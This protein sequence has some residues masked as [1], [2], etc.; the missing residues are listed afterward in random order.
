[1][2]MPMIPHTVVST[3]SQILGDTFLM[4]RFEG[5]SEAM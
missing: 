5:T 4:T 3:P 1:M 2:D